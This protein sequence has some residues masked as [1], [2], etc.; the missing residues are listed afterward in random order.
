MKRARASLTG[1]PHMPEDTPGITE[2]ASGG[3]SRNTGEF[4]S[5]EPWTPA[6]VRAVMWRGLTIITCPCCIPIWLAVL[7]GTVIGALLSKNIFI[8]VALL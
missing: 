7:S 3:T 6:R 2:H 4:P 1:L 5:Q 8:T